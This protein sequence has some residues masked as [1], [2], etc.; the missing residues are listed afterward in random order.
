MRDC[1][2][3]SMF[4]WLDRVFGTHHLPNVWPERYGIEEPMPDTLAGQFVE[5]FVPRSRSNRPEPPDRRRRR[6]RMAE[7][8]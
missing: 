6:L 5:P 8:E 4:P 2:Y 3:A 7:L 1:N